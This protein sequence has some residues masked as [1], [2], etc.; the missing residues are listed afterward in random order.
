[1]AKLFELEA[2][3]V[4][5]AGNFQKDMGDA[6]EDAKKLSSEIDN[7]NT[8]QTTGSRTSLSNARDDASNISSTMT[9]ASKTAKDVDKDLGKAKLKGQ[10]VLSA[11]NDM[12]VTVVANLIEQLITGLIEGIGEAIEVAAQQNTRVAMEYNVASGINDIVTEMAQIKKGETW[13]PI[14]TDAVRG[15]TNWMQYWN[16][17]SGADTLLYYLDKLEQVK[18]ENLENVAKNIRSVFK[19]FQEVEYVDPYSVEEMQQGLIS[20]AEYWE[21]YGRVV[22]SL[23]VKGVSDE[24]LA[25]YATGTV[26]SFAQLSALDQASL[27][28]VTNTMLAFERT[29]GAEMGVAE[30][31]SASQ[32]ALSDEADLVGATIYTMVQGLDQSELA[33]LN[34]GETLD[35]VIET[36]QDRFPEYA[37]S[38][39]MWAAE[40]AKLVASPAVSVPE[41][42]SGV[43]MYNNSLQYGGSFLPFASGLEYVPY[44]GYLAELHRGETVLTRQQAEERRNGTYGG[45]FDA[46]TLE[47]AL[48]G[49][50][51]RWGQPMGETGFAAV[52]TPKIS[53]DIARGIRGSF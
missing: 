51:S 25:R 32:M 42:T 40:G 4:L 28:D 33:Q 21:E 12:L 39:A 50:L 3:I 11:L 43:E 7:I 52:M 9:S 5:N 16:D 46:D 23:K 29:A 37:Q 14:A 34:M 22:E 36:I 26:Q 44:D 15:Q 49:A 31:I 24:F 53:H 35:A 19:A 48:F 20:Q 1:M 41:S 38:I 45:T 6:V 8:P 10:Q 18:L 30:S 2:D 27:E 17:I 47:N 13:L